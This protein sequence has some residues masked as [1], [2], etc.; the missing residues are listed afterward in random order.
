MSHIQNGEVGAN[1]RVSSAWI[2]AIGDRSPFAGSADEA[3]EP[4]TPLYACN[5]GSSEAGLSKVSRRCAPEQGASYSTYC[6]VAHVDCQLRA[7]Q[8]SE[9]RQGCTDFQPDHARSNRSAPPS[10]LDCDRDKRLGPTCQ[11]T[12]PTR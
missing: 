5:R 10:S 12:N 3:R 2:P 1:R 7:S 6:R 8:R 11:V 9:R 4:W